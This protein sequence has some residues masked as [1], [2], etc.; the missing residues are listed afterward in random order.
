[1]RPTR[2]HPQFAGIR[3]VAWE[4]V[5][6][7]G[8]DVAVVSTAHDGVDHAALAHAIPLVIDTRGGCPDAPNVV[9]A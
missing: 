7:G 8:F 3:S 5:R 4:D 9:R 1:V 2:E 6:A